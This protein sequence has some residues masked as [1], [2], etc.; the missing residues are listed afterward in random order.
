V[1]APFCF[2][3]DFTEAGNPGTGSRGRRM[4]HVNQ[5]RHSLIPS[6]FDSPIPYPL[7]LQTLALGVVLILAAWLRW[8][9]ILHVQPYPDEF[10]TLL[11]VK[12]ILQKGLPLLPSGLF[13]D[14]GLL[15]SYAGGLASALFGFSREA[16]RA[17]SLVFDLLTVLLVWHVGR[18]WFSAEAGLVAATLMA[19]A[20]TAVLWGGRARMYALL[21][22]LVLLTLY[23]AFAGT[24][25]NSLSAYASRFRRLALFSYLAATLTQF[26]SIALIPPLALGT[27]VVGWYQARQTG[28]RPWF[29]SRRVWWELGGL[30]V[31]VLAAFLVKRMGQPKSVA[32]LQIGGAGILTGIVQVVAIYGAFSTDL[33]V[34]WDTLA[35][36]F[37]APEAIVP[38]LLALLAIAWCGVNLVRR[39]TSTRDLATLFLALIL[40]ATTVEMIFFVAPDRRDEKYLV[41]LLP[42]FFLLA[43]DGATR[44]TQFQIPSLPG[45]RG[46]PVPATQV[47]AAGA[48]KSRISNLQS[49]ILGLAICLLL[50]I[51]TWPFTS[52]LLAHTGPDYDTAFGYVRDHWKTGDAILTGTPAAAA[53][54]L[55]RND[56]YAVEG[57]GGYAYRILQRDGQQV[58]R[59]LGS[60]WLETDEQLRAAFDA[61]PR[62]WLVLER[63]GL[64]QEYYSPLTMQRIL[65]MTDFVREDNGVVVLRSRP[66]AAFIPENP[67]ASLAANFDNQLALQGYDLTWQATGQKSRQLSLVLYW[68]VLSSIPYDYTV[69]VHLRDA[70]GRNVAQA[71]HQPL[72]PVYPPTLWPVGQ[73][74]RERSVL[75]LPEGIAAGTYN[76]WVGLYRLDTLERLPVVSG[77][78]SDNALLLGQEI[79]P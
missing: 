43:A 53:I 38:T 54:Y 9:Y 61:A 45:P 41:M 76:L 20:P 42:A 49:P 2:A 75:T 28:E 68:P 23:C 16:V 71:D 51:Y 46:A 27:V 6:S 19:V 74:I 14:H 70:A 12:M 44:L 60:P 3:Y 59:W 5:R 32:P 31:I 37:T 52:A 22:L 73:T 40:A 64:I 18:R 66:A 4:A 21:Q 67:S 78:S 56:Y 62:V 50:L 1:R 8:Y 33:A 10:V 72:A 7:I 25:A 39:R 29:R 79:I 30:A 13:Y 35:P 11:A 58:D 15:F 77:S 47:Q 17:T 63:W 34:S 36:F 48:G 24:S 55:G 65:A 26:V 57:S 69:F